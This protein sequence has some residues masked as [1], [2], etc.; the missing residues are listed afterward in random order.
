MDNAAEIIFGRDWMLGKERVRI[1]SIEPAPPNANPEYSGPRAEVINTEGIFYY[2]M[3]HAL[4][5]A[6]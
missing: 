1:R 2:V 3:L 6:K 5:E 4:T